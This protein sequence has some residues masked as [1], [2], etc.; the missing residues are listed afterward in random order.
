M[1]YKRR[2]EWLEKA[3]WDLWDN[4]IDLTVTVNKLKENYE[5]KRSVL[6]RSQGYSEHTDLER[7]TA[8]KSTIWT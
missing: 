8:K 2:I 5:T 1:F 6:E 4:Y 7:N 3:Y